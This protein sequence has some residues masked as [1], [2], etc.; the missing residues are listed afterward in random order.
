MTRTAT[1]DRARRAEDDYFRRKDAELIEKARRAAAPTADAVSEAERRALADTFGVHDMSLIRPLH[2][3]GFRPAHAPLLDWMPAVDVAWVGS[4][5]IVER[6]GLRRQI[7]ADPRAVEA[8]L[9][10]IM[11]FLSVQPPPE[12][13]AAVRE[14]LRRQLSAMDAVTR[15]ERFDRILARCEAVGRASG[16]WLGIGAVSL[17]ERRRMAAIRAGLAGADAEPSV[18]A[19]DIPQ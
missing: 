19:H 7:A 16:G 18:E 17:D 13:M 12:L 8:G 9:P 1:N 10:L 11:G 4:V 6:E 2:A 14:L 5:D 15:R 3:A